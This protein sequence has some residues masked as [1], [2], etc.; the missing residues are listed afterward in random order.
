MI[1]NKPLTFDRVIRI[2]ITLLIVYGIFLFVSYIQEVLIPFAIAAILAYFI[3]PLVSFYQY[4]C[5]IKYRAPAVLLALLSVLV[6][7]AGLLLLFI[8]LIVSEVKQMATL[9]SNLSAVQNLEAR[10]QTYL[11]EDISV[12]VAEMTRKPEVKEIFNTEKFSDYALT[13]VKTVIPGIWNFFSGAVNFILG[14][15]GLA[16]IALYLIFILLDYE[17]VMQGWK[18]LVSERY[19]DR[20]VRVVDDFEK[21]MSTYFRAQGMIAFIVGILFAIGFSLIGLPLGVLFGLFV[22]LLNL[23]PYLQTVAIVPA[24]FL[25]LTRSL[26]TGDNFWALM[27]LVLLVFAVVQLAQDAILTPRIMGKATG[28]NPAAML[29]ALSVWGKVLGFLG[30]IIALPVTFLLL[31]YYKDLINSK[32]MVLIPDESLP[33]ESPPE[34]PESKE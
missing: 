33:V 3:H 22:G 28:L 14:L 13:G 6:V 9:L 12:W 5:R 24:G 4:R 18:G 27:G 32:N 30:L 11:P 16:V 17:K 21:A 2:G 29:L 31:S 19:R 34:E 1:T 15:V 20:V 10:I 25:A 7:F 8:P 26:E 23:V